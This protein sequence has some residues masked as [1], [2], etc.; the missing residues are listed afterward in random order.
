MANDTIRKGQIKGKNYERE[1][2]KKINTE[3]MR[4]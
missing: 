1:R 3:R 2:K 4:K